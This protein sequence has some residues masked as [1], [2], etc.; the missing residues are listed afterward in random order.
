MRF[1][2]VSVDVISAALQQLNIS[3][4]SMNLPI[5][6]FFKLFV[7]LHAF[8]ED[9]VFELFVGRPEDGSAFK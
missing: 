5:E 1:C 3:F 4:E 2:Y 9:R 7:A 8:P 6:I